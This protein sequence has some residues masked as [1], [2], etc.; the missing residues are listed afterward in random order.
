MPE[1]D[2]LRVHRNPAKR[3]LP[4]MVVDETGAV[5]LS[6]GSALM[7]ATIAVPL[8]WLPGLVTFMFGAIRAVSMGEDR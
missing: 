8:A 2:A 3:F 6:I 5:L 1:E 4:D 7:G